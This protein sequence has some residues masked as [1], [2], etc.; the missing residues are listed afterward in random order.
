M[1][2]WETNARTSEKK[3]ERTRTSDENLY[4]YRYLERD[5]NK[6]FLSL[7][8]K[9]EKSCALYNEDKF[10]QNSRLFFSQSLLFLAAAFLVITFL[11]LRE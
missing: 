1:N 6:F 8:L 3:G 7:S 5:I 4:M 2:E 11:C 10:D 9:Y